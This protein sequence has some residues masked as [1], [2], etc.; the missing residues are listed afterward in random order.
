MASNLIPFVDDQEDNQDF[1]L[2]SPQHALI[3]ESLKR[4][5]L[6]LPEGF[7]LAYTYGVKKT[8]PTPEQFKAL[9]GAAGVNPEKDAELRNAQIAELR[10]LSTI[11]SQHPEPRSLDLAPAY[12]FSKGIYGRDVTPQTPAEKGGFDVATQ[13][14]MS[15]KMNELIKA[16]SEEGMKLA[17]L[18][19]KLG[20]VE[21]SGKY[22]LG[23]SRQGLGGGL[24]EKD[25]LRMAME[26][27]KRLDP[28]KIA[29]ANTKLDDALK[30]LGSFDPNDNST[31]KGLGQYG[32]GWFER[33]TDPSAKENY[34]RVLDAI[35]EA[36]HQMY[37]SALSRTEAEN[38]MS[39]AGISWNSPPSS[40]RGYLHK[41]NEE[42][43]QFIEG[44]KAGFDPEV[45]SMYGS[46]AGAI[47]TKPFEKRQQT[48]PTQPAKKS[49]RELL[50]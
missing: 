14:A 29:R 5:A 8:P 28:T 40:V 48:A 26:L 24:T 32:K 45:Q 13:L 37:G 47:S 33:L 7:N 9:L 25:K 22:Q 44:T 34:G 11:L 1:G 31:I 21:P 42:Y 15:A 19:S 18:A 46:R 10:D 36:R 35:A 3:L 27:G 23:H 30:V 17:A 39:Q 16:G 50:K 20:T 6:G 2:Q 43:K 12:A 49:A 38:A 4:K 41:L